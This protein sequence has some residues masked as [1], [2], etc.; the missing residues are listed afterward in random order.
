M[1]RVPLTTCKFALGVA[2]ATAALAP[3]TALANRH[4]HHHHAHATRSAPVLADQQV[5]G[6]LQSVSPTTIVISH[7]T[8]GRAVRRS[9]LTY[10][11]LATTFTAQT[12]AAVFK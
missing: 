10:S 6:T 3:G 2:A 4:H 12:A 1:H 5:D 9:T 8:T 7:I 11:T